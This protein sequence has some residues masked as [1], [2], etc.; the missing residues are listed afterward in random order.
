MIA[1]KKC[2]ILSAGLYNFFLV[3]EPARFSFLSLEM[4]VHLLHDT[5]NFSGHGSTFPVAG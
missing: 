4:P 1:A 3:L 2:D 5:P